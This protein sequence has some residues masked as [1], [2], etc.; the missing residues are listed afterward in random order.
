VTDSENISRLGTASVA[1]LLFFVGLQID[2]NTLV[3]NWKLIIFGILMQ[4]I[5][6]ICSVWLLGLWYDWSIARVVLIGFVIS[7]S[8]P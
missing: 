1:L 2:I 8:R 3:S 4:I 7:L 5:L 6:S